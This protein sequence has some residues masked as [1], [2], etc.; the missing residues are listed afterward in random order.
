MAAIIIPQITTTVWSPGFPLP[1]NLYA[2]SQAACMSNRLPNGS[3]VTD[4][5]GLLC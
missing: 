4:M 1:R 5:R 2:P 3:H